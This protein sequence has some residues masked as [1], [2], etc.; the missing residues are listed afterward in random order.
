VKKVP[1]ETTKK[2]SKARLNG[3]VSNARPYDARWSIE[4]V[5][6]SAKPRP[7]KIQMST[8]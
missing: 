6:D 2:T 1:K 8:E 3:P 5:N 7:E 4:T